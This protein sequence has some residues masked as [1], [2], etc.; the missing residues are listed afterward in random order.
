MPWIIYYYDDADVQ[1]I[2]PNWFIP[3]V[4]TTGDY[5]RNIAEAKQFK[6]LRDAKHWLWNNGYQGEWIPVEMGSPLPR[7]RADFERLLEEKRKAN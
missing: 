6:A 7:T 1:R 3:D 4:F 5:T 2:R